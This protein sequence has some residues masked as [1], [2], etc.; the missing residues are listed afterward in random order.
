MAVKMSFIAASP[1][2]C[3]VAYL[4]LK[5]KRVCQHVFYNWSSTNQSNYNILKMIDTSQYNTIL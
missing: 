1:T 2:L 5:Y 3:I 4:L